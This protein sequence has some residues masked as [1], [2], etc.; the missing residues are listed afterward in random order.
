[1]DFSR[2]KLLKMLLSLLRISCQYYGKLRSPFGSDASQKE[3]DTPEAAVA[4]L[5]A[6]AKKDGI[7]NGYAPISQCLQHL[8]P[9][10]QMQVTASEV[11]N[12]LASGRKMEALQCAQE[13]HLWGPALVIAAQLGDQ[14]YV[15]TVKQM[16]LRQL[17]PGSPLRTLCLLVAGQPAEVCPTGSSSSMLDNWEE[18]LG[19]ITANRTTDDDL[20]IIHLGDSMWKERG[21]V[22]LCLVVFFY[23][24]ED[25]IMTFEVLL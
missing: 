10:S 13:G 19:I 5:F 8:P 24:M 16:A 22:V 17:I 7:Q 3:T 15:D 18:N 1:M 9:E 2:G 6:F 14:F 12:L 20:V 4:K 21:E 25:F 23:F 11:Q